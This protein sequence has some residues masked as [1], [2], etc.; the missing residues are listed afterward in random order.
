MHDFFNVMAVIVLL[1][2]QVATGFLSKGAAEV[3]GLL[4]GRIELGP[5]PDSPIKSAVKAPVSWV[6][7]VLEDLGA[8]SEVAG[9]ILLLTGVGLIFVC[10]FFITRNMRALL[11]GRIERSMNAVLAS[12]AGIAA[13]G[14]GLVITVSVQSSS[15]T[16][17]MLIPLIASGVLLL[18]NAYPITL[19]ANLGTTVTALLASLAATGP[20]ALVVALSHTL[21]NLVGIIVFYP[22]RLLRQ[23]PLRLARGLADVAIARKRWAAVYVVGGFI[24]VPLVGLLLLR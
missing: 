10:L 22:I 18:E 8:S 20:A 23:L 13:M 9:I 4:R 12:G 7:G 11:A 24:V 5:A 19:G 1:P 16:T 17:S 14:V 2:L 3:A 21:F 15:I 6:Q